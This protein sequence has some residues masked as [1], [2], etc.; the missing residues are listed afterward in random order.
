MEENGAKST[1]YTF[2]TPFWAQKKDQPEGWSLKVEKV[3]VSYCR[4]GGDPNAG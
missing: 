2:P 3:G 4:P 1:E